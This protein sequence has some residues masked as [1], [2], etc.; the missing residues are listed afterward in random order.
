MTR[1]GTRPVPTDHGFKPILGRHSPSHCVLQPIS[2]AVQRSVHL[3][4]RTTLTRIFFCSP[5]KRHASLLSSPQRR[6]CC[7]RLGSQRYVQLYL[8]FSLAFTA[9]SHTH[10]E[11][12]KTSKES[13]D[14]NRHRNAVLIPLPPQSLPKKQ[15]LPHPSSP[16]TCSH[17]CPL[18]CSH[19]GEFPPTSSP[20]VIARCIRPSL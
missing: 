7:V 9:Q 19:L 13:F 1:H 12:R 10:R 8:L 2:V 3:M 18:S 6:S 11:R 5:K 4:S 17:H 16:I 20:R 15:H 14:A